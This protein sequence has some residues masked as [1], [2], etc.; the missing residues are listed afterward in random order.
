MPGAWKSVP[1]L[2]NRVAAPG[3]LVYGFEADLFYANANLF[4]KQLL[5]LVSAADKP[6]RA[7]VLDASGIDNVDYTAAKMLLE[8]GKELAKRDIA[9]SM[10]ATFVGV[11]D[12][13]RRYRLAD[14]H[15]SGLGALD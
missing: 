7:V 9:F 5:H 14:D 6:I 4:M 11:L 12:D 2:P 3:L 15:A 8:V 13:L 1:A 10:V